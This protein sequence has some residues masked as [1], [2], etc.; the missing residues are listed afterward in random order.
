MLRIAHAK[1]VQERKANLA[2]ADFREFQFCFNVRAERPG[3]RLERLA[4]RQNQRASSS[5]ADARP[6]LRWP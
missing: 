2:G 5:S 6:A 3:I 4:A 1:E